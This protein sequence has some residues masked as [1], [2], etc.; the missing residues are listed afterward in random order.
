MEYNLKNI[1][2][3]TKKNNQAKN[4][5]IFKKLL[6]IESTGLSIEINC[7]LLLVQSLFLLLQFVVFGVYSELG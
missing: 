5:Q 4:I 6:F 3:I 1:A 7:K 2:D